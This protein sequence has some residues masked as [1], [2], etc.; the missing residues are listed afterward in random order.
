MYEC[1]YKFELED[2]IICAK[3]VY[4]SQKRKQDKIIAI[5]IPVLMAIMVGMLVYDIVMQRSFVWD[6]VLLV[7]LLALEVMYLIIPVMLVRAQKKSYNSQKL[8]EMDSL[9]IKIDDNLCVE[10]LLKDGQEVAKNV[11]NLKQ[12][13][14]YLEDNDRLILVFNKVE[15]ACIRKSQLKGDL[16]KL[17]SHLE[18]IMTKTQSY[19]KKK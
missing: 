7:A 12:L 13:T 11:H 15:F 17:K 14:S 1:D 3:Y 6:I 4:K 5:M 18:K 2:S 8:G 10:T 9:H 19:N 16:N